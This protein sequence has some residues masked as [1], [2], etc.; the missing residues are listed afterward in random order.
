M[1]LMHDA[2]LKAYFKRM[3]EDAYAGTMFESND[4]AD[5]LSTKG[6][7]EVIVAEVESN[8]GLTREEIWL[9]IVQEHFMRYRRSDFLSTVQQ[10]V[11]T[12]VLNCPTPRKTKRLNDS[13]EL[14]PTQTSAI[15]N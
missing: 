14:Y 7:K 13:C 11:D 12:G 2:M 8:P 5:M 3:H 15:P 9:R 6:L 10:L 1:L 4:W